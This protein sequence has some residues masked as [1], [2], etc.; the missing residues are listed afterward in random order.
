MMGS[1]A[2]IQR[3]DISVRPRL[4]SYLS[5]L[6]PR[7]ALNL[8]PASDRA[9]LTVVQHTSFTFHLFKLLSLLL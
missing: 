3:V 8:N 6:G 1:L 7:W 2:L 4:L 9:F 5:L